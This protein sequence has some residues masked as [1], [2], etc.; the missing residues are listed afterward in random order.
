MQIVMVLVPLMLLLVAVGI[1]LF[2]WAVKSGQYDDVEGPAHRI[3]YDDD[4]A[5]IPKEARVSNPDQATDENADDDRQDG[6][7]RT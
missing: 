7:P 1:V 4:E 2:A 6:D 3:L 5:M